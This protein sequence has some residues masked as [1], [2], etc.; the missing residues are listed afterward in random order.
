[1]MGADRD[2]LR[3]QLLDEIVEEMHGMKGAVLD[4]FLSHAGFEP[5]DLLASFDESLRLMEAAAGRKRFDAAR[6]LLSSS[7]PKNNVLNLEVSRKR[8]VFAAVKDRM[9]STG[10][11]TLAARN[12]KIESEDDLDSFL[13]ACVRLGIIN[14]YGDLKD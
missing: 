13:E 11:M 10:E 1:M 2:P 6:A 7:R 3:T 9:E 8:S 12:K 14:E 4:E 5:S